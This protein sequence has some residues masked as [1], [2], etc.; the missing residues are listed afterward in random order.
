MNNVTRTQIL[1]VSQLNQT[2][3]LLLESE[4][5]TLWLTGEISN[6]S[7][8]VSGHWYFTL[9]DAQAQV[10]CAMFRMAN[11]S[12]GFTPQHGQQVLI[13]ASVTLYEARGDYQ[14]IVQSMQPAGDGLLQ[15]RYEQLKKR[16]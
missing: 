6:F 4:L 15:Q 5:N 3:K 8:P 16:L 2:V 14:L 10:R 11:R 12:V 7:Q 9:K 1:T 13:R